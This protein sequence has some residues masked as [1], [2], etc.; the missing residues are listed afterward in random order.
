MFFLL[1][2]FIGLCSEFGVV[3]AKI[4]LSGDHK[5]LDAVTKS[6]IAT[7]FGYR[8]SLMEYLVTSKKCYLRNPRTK[9]Q[10]PNFI[11]TLVE[12]YRSHPNILYIPDRL[13]YDDTLLAKGRISM[14]KK[15]IQG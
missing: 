7:Q 11:V 1:K 9:K 6:R 4:V 13:F 10:N 5:Q 12:N 2:L 8:T 3:K 14:L 15:Y